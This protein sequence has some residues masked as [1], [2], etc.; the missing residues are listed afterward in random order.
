MRYFI[1]LLALSL[2]SC[3]IP[4]EE[5][6]SAIYHPRTDTLSII[7][8]GMLLELNCQVHTSQIGP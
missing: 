7:K 6:D 5:Q 4:A 2:V 1:V 3:A 8:T